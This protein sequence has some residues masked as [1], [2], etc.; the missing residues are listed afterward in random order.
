MPYT[1]VF[2]NV[3]PAPRTIA[4][5]SS[6]NVYTAN[7]G[8]N[9][10]TKITP[11]GVVTLVW[12]T[13]GAVPQDLVIDSSGN[14]YSANSTAGTISKVTPAGVV[15]LVWATVN[16]NVN[17]LVI[18]FSGNIYSLGTGGI[19]K[20][21][22]TGVVTLVWAAVGSNTDKMLLDRITGNIYISTNAVISKITS[23][24]TITP[25]WAICGGS[26]GE[27][28]TDSMGNVYVCNTASGY[29]AIHKIPSVG[30]LA[31]TPW[32]TV[33]PNPIDILIDKCGDV[34][35][36]HYSG[37]I[38]KI[39]PTGIV[40]LGYTTTGTYPMEIAEDSFSDLY[41]ANMTDATVTKIT[42]KIRTMVI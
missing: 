28:A 40:T 26:L 18:D 34:Y 11:A 25:N 22:P 20:I 16:A 4:I 35:V 17:S 5:D 37:S 30:G 8:N 3:G 39:T 2:A 23:A 24:G 36:L 32:V 21:T 38:T 41:V 13:V 29:E 19:S 14:V 6:G 42:Q 7:S 31:L 27:M 12:A 15:T 9:T 10:I 1:G 33:E